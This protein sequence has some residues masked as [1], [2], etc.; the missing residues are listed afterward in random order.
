MSG[1]SLQVLISERQKHNPCTE[2][3]SNVS[4]RFDASLT[5]DFEITPKCAALFLSLRFHQANSEYIHERLRLAGDYR[6]RLLLVYVD[7][8]DAT[9]LIK[10]ITEICFR[11]G[12]IPL[13]AWSYEEVAIYIETAKSYELKPIDSLMGRISE[14]GYDQLVD[15]ITEVK[16]LNKTDAVNMIKKFGSLKKMTKA[17]KDQL[18]SIPG[19]GETKA[20]N[21]IGTCNHKLNTNKP[22]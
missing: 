1:G 12:Y 3:L 18:M 6:T 13:L 15:A 14:N 8:Q 10:E 19:F 21:W 20:L 22:K 7:M 9:F 5:V 17:T 11:T 2:L 16:T 4:W